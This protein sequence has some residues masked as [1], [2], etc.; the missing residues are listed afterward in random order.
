MFFI[1][2]YRILWNLIS[3]GGYIFIKNI[4][5]TLITYFLKIIDAAYTNYLKY[6]PMS[7]TDLLN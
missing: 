4:T 3:N 6:N 7:W 1:L 5:I 2:L